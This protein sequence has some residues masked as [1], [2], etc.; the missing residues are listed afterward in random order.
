[1]DLVATHGKT[2]KEKVMCGPKYELLYVGGMVQSTI[3]CK[4]REAAL[5]SVLVD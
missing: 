4:I 2:V 3:C 5:L 1:M